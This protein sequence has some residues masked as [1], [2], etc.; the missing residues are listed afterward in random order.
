MSTLHDDL[1]Q[2]VFD[3]DEMETKYKE[4]M[5]EWLKAQRSYAQLQHKLATS[6]DIERE[7]MVRKRRRL[8]TSSSRYPGRLDARADA[9]RVGYRRAHDRNVEERQTKGKRRKKKNG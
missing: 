3:K 5:R 8:R 2:A 6:V 9:R 4:L 1:D 7:K